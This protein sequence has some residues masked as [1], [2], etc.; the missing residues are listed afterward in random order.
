MSEEISPFELNR[1]ENED[2]RHYYFLETAE[3]RKV[4]GA[5]KHCFV[6]GHRGTGK[7]S[8]LRAMEW[9]ERT[10]NA[11][12]AASLKDD[13]F[14]DGVVG[15]YFGL[16]YIHLDTVDEWVAQSSP[17]L[18][19]DILSSYLRA[20]W[21]EEASIAVASLRRDAGISSLDV[22]IQELAPVLDSWMDWLA[23][24][25]LARPDEGY[26][27]LKGIRRTAVALSSEI[28]ARAS[29]LRS[30]PEG[31]VRDLSLSRLPALVNEIFSVLARMLPDRPKGKQPWLFQMCL[32]E[33]EY[34][35]EDGRRTVRSM[36]RECRSPLLMTVAS[37]DDLGVETLNPRVRLTVNDRLLLDLRSRTFKE[38]AALINGVVNTRLRTLED[39]P[40]FR[41]QSLL[42]TFDVG[43]LLVKAQTE[44]PS[45]RRQIA[46]WSERVRAGGIEK[47]SPVR[48]FLAGSSVPTDAI[49]RRAAD[50]AG[51]RKKH[52]AGY[53]RLLAILGITRPVYAGAPIVLTMME[54]SLRDLFM[55]LERCF[56][57]S[58][59]RVP[60][61][62]M[63][64]RLRRFIQKEIGIRVQDDAL[65]YVARQKMEN[66]QE[67]IVNLTTLSRQL[68]EFL[69]LV[70]HRLDM[71][72]TNSEI[73]TPE[74]TM[75]VVRVPSSENGLDQRREE[76]ARARAILE[77]IQN[78][79]R[80]GYLVGGATSD[81][82]D[83]LH[84]RVNRSLAKLHGFSYRAPQY[85]SRLEWQYLDELA[86]GQGTPERLA[87]RATEALLNSGAKS[88]SRIKQTSQLSTFVPVAL[89]DED[90]F[91]S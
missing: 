69:S 31:A 14:S 8:L 89:F 18:K 46:E 24:T 41:I 19:H 85:E 66:L 62:D 43:E 42:S 45:S 48:E 52:V 10:S 27:S 50:S 91:L 4:R 3:Y 38:F 22:E 80:E 9:S 23:G 20:L 53:L 67:R 47:W 77:A 39:I 75:F 81:R 36:V 71:E 76:H 5:R 79:V 34:L 28:Y 88:T 55:F 6:I 68:V 29:D 12:L 84:V 30:D 78:C 15:C 33:G 58:T 49:E 40:E 70:S 73:R 11:S 87:A 74:R 61:V 51:Y 54:S 25:T 32:D 65:T 72:A 17:H 86:L 13:P 1:W 59:P 63:A 37:L 56:V 7:T 44:R 60:G 16:Q 64:G 90:E 83:V 35:S 21:L 2:A 57:A 26:L 82:P